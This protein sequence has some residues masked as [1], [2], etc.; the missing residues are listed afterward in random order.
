MFV[1]DLVKSLLCGL[2]KFQFYHIDGILCF[3]RNV[4][5]SSESMLFHQYSEIRKQGKDDI[6]CLLIMPLIIGIIAIRYRLPERF[7]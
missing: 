3:H 7:Q 1:V 5:S 6:H 4:C 2:I